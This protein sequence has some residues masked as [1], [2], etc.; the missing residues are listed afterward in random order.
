MGAIILISQKKL[1]LKE[2]VS[3]PQGHST[4]TCW[5]QDWHLC[6]CFSKSQA[7]ETTPENL[8]ENSDSR[9]SEDNSKPFLGK[10]CLHSPSELFYPIRLNSRFWVA[11][12]W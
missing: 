3:F 5:S 6:L 11:I 8:S 4:Y 1:S 12:F 7:K 2:A 9:P 10:S